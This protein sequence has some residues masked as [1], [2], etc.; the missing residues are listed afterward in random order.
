MLVQVNG[1]Y[2]LQRVTG[3]QRYAR[4]IVARLSDRVTVIS[5]RAMG[6]GIRGHLWEQAI[7]PWRLSRG[8]LWSPCA[9]GPLAAR[10]HVLTVHDCAFFD[11][12]ECFSP[13]F[14]RW[15]QCLMPRLARRA[16]RVLTV[17][18]FSKSRIAERLGVAS[19]KI[20]VAP[21][22]VSRD[23]QPASELQ[24]ADARQR[25]A[26]GRPYVLYVGSLEPRKNLRRLLAA[27]QHLGA[28]KNDAVLLLAGAAGHVFRDAGLDP[29]PTDVRPLGFVPD[30]DL[31]ALF[32]GAEAFVFPSL[33]EGFGL[34]VLEAM[35]CGAPVIASQAGAIPEVAGDAALLVD[36]LN[37]DSIAA[38]LSQ[39]LG[40]RELRLSLRE[41]GFARAAGFNWDHTAQQVWD[42]L[43]TA[44]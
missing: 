8:V 38:G 22:G 6:R 41:R 21:P 1:R 15:Y 24:I 16:A 40:S 42:V 34:P 12:P 26:D 7:L 2:L 17:S 32:S 3:V 29:L 9:T 4:E 35:A 39:V 18:H 36:P 10:N 27:W 23:W 37:T 19:D 43:T 20:I 30:D 44:I 14:A 33:Y 13:T 5:P 31:R 11:C 25:F 28:H